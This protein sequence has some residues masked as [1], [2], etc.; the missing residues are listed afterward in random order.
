MSVR[1]KTV[2]TTRILRLEKIDREIPKMNAGLRGICRGAVIRTLG[3][4][5]V[6]EA[7]K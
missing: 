7:L 4:N 3:L 1:A 2:V 5:D 6:P